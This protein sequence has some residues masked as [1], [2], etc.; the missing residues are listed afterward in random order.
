MFYAAKIHIIYD[1]AGIFA[2]KVALCVVN[3][4]FVSFFRF[5]SQKALPIQKKVVSLQRSCKNRNTEASAQH[6][7][8]TPKHDFATAFP[9]KTH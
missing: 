2:K 3:N 5:F 9:R 4:P 8:P 1:C 6:S 7:G